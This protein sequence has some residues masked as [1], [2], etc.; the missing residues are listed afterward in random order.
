MAVAKCTSPYWRKEYYL[1]HQP[2]EVQL[3]RT[4]I[5]PLKKELIRSG[6]SYKNV[7]HKYQIKHMNKKK[8]MN[9]LFQNI[10]IR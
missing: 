9:N 4:K 3:Y 8:Q 2:V 5:Y 7:V 10:L 6:I 1:I